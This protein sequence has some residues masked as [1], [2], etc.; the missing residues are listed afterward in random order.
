MESL[1]LAGMSKRELIKEHYGYKTA[2]S[3]EPDS[4][5]EGSHCSTL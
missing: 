5:H 3:Q 2:T 4:D 1:V